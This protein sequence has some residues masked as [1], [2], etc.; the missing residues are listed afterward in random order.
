MI[1]KV[2]LE[3]MARD[4]CPACR[5][6]HRMDFNGEKGHT[7]RQR[8]DTKEWVHDFIKPTAKD[9]SLFEHVFCQADAL[10]KKYG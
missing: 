9:T 7:L 8:S 5:R 4:I 10:R 3:Q 1:S 2:K 6:A